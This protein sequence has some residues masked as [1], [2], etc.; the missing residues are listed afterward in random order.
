VPSKR[1]ARSGRRTDGR[2][3]DCRRRLRAG[4][5]VVRAGHDGGRG[6]R[7]SAGTRRRPVQDGR[8][9]AYTARRW[10]RRRL[11]V[12]VHR[13]GT[14][15]RRQRVVVVE[16]GEG[17]PHLAPGEGSCPSPGRCSALP[18]FGAHDLGAAGLAGRRTDPGS[19]CMGSAWH[20]VPA[21]NARTLGAREAGTLV[22]PTPALWRS[23]RRAHVVQGAGVAVAAGLAVGSDS[24]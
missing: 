13:L 18:S 14:S 22:P 8:G 10:G 17:L 1:T 4:V 15:S 5:C 11:P 2:V 12:V 21:G 9:P 16:A 20:Y 24:R 3:A 19:H 23:C 6:R 7:P